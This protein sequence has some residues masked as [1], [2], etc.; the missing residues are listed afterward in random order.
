MIVKIY[1]DNPNYQDVNKIVNELESGAVIIYPTSTGYAYAAHA[2]NPKAIER[3]CDI[4]KIDVKKKSLSIMFGTMSAVSEYCK[5]ND[6][7]FKFIKEHDG[8]YTFILPAASTLP[9]IF[10]SRK[11]LGVRFA[12]HPVAKIIIEELGV[13]LITS[14]LPYDDYEPEYSSDPSLVYERYGKD[15]DLLVDGGISLLS[16]STI[17]DCTEEPFEVLRMGSGRI[18]DEYLRKEE[19]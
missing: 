18:E 8:N 3:I 9:K 2:L 15:V 4:K 12:H 16:P 7:A 6:R 1:P 13:P 10:K 17:V 11:E 5:M 19:V 14:S